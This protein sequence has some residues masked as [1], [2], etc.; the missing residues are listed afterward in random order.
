MS[1]PYRVDVM[2][3][4]GDTPPLWGSDS[5]DVEPSPADLARGTWRP[6]HDVPSAEPAPPRPPV[7]L[8]SDGLLENLASWQVDWENGDWDS[9]A[10]QQEWWLSGL[11]LSRQVQSELGAG[12]IVTY[13][14][15]GLE[16]RD[17]DWR[18][19]FSE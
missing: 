5:D 17:E 4:W 6:S 8:L 18:S 19:M 16:N 7:S 12:W 9:K 13:Y 3:D 15:E 1:E 11:S 10:W 14:G 2:A